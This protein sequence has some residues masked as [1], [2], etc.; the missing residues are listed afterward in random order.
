MNLS[1]EYIVITVLASL[2]SGV[3]GVL[4]SSIYYRRVEQRKIKLDTAR[5]LFG[6]R[7]NM[8]GAEFTA[9]MNEIPIVFADSEDVIRATKKFYE[10]VDAGLF[11]ERQELYYSLLA[12]IMKEMG[13]FKVHF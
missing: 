1:G 3:I 10:A 5:R 8:R 12:E 4:I 9:A 6:N 7:R 2:L 11:N 13:F